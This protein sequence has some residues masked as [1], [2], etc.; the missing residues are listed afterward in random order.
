MPGFASIKAVLIIALWMFLLFRQPFQLRS[1]LWFLSVLLNLV[2]WI[3]IAIYKTVVLSDMTNHL[4]RLLVFFLVLAIG[5]FS[6]RSGK[7][8]VASLDRLIVWMAG[9][10]A[11]LKVVVL[12]LMVSGVASLEHIQKAIGF[13][14]VT[15]E[16]GFGI[17]R[18]QFPS[19][20]ILI[21]LVACY[22]GG[23]RKSTDLFLLICVTVSVFLSFS[24]YLFAAYV[25]CMILR[26][27]KLKRVD[28]VSKSGLIAGV[29]LLA[30]FSVSL[31]RRFVSAGTNASD[32]VRT[33]QIH[34]LRGVIARNQALGTG[35]GSSVPG[36]KRS[37]AMP[38]SYEVEWYALLM[39]FGAFGLVWFVVNL[40]SPLVVSLRA[41][42]NKLF[43]LLILLIWA[44]AGFTNPLVT[45][46]GSAFG[47]CI[48][49][50]RLAQDVEPEIEVEAAVT[51]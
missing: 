10:S 18:L 15:D 7:T 46:L 35:V 6:C 30:F 42:A 41:G 3:E 40:L 19:D 34:E 51:A 24:R 36:Y 12:T 13:E 48:L 2:G 23:R 31:V 28:I 44:G 9:L 17:Q 5:A 45:S 47:L 33:D 22:V 16:I 1:V 39:Q 50:L 27:V 21:F 43:F 20:V 32:S 29:V 38:F 26:A 14:T 37:E 4:S 11:G 8:A 25:I 49:M